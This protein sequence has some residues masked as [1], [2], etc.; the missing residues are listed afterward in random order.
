MNDK[1]AG[2]CPYEMSDGNPCGRSLYDGKRCIC[3]SEQA[4][5]D[6]KLFQEE[7]DKVFAEP[8]AKGVHDL[9]GFVFP[10]GDL[11]SP[12]TFARD[13]CFDEAVFLGGASFSNKTF[14]GDASFEGT[15]F[16]ELVQFT[17]VSINGRAYFTE[18]AFAAGVYFNNALFRGNAYFYR[19]SFKGRIGFTNKTSFADELLFAEAMFEPSCK[20]QFSN[21]MFGGR[22]NFK[23]ADIRGQVHFKEVEFPREFAFAECQLSGDARVEFTQEGKAVNAAF[24]LEFD[25]VIDPAETRSVIARAANAVAP[26]PPRSGKKRAFIDTW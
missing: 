16:L 23:K 2:T 3:H 17:N 15:Q 6:V 26:P 22:V 25:A 10:E 13:V 21:V 1:S 11:Q 4:D 18:A 7:L 12:P 19:S 5:K 24:H 14:L 8:N 9:I 20:M